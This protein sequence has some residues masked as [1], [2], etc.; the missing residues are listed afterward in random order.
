MKSFIL[1]LL[2]ITATYVSA[3]EIIPVSSLSDGGCF[4]FEDDRDGRSLKVASFNQSLAFNITE[5]HMQAIKEEV[6]KSFEKFEFDFSKNQHEVYIH[7]GAYGQSMVFNIDMEGF[8]ACVWAEMNQH[9][10]HVRNIGVTDK[11]G[12]CDGYIPGRLVIY[13]E[14]DEGLYM[15]EK[16]LSDPKW[17]RMITYA[18]SGGYNNIT[19]FLSDEYTF[20]EHK[21]KN[22]LMDSIDK[23]Y[24][25]AIEVENLYHPIG[26][27]KY[28]KSFSS[29]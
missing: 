19:I 2:I 7:C 22:A 18:S 5:N 10:V 24:Y 1:L 14:G 15:I 13:T 28:I 11:F 16:E 12:P 20:S 21:V 17:R 3:E 25:K 6:N 29:N 27:F 23:M 26:E 4:V 9:G 8:N